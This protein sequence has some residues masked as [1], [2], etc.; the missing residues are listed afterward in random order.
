MPPEKEKQNGDDEITR[1]WSAIGKVSRLANRHQGMWVVVGVILVV[2]LASLFTLTK[3]NNDA[4]QIAIK[5]IGESS[6][7]TAENTD[8]MK[9][10][11]T[12]YMAANQERINEITRRIERCEE[13]LK[14]VRR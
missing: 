3:M 13:E 14:D 4:N 7:K 2:A 12:A 9:L 5:A 6:E 1:I 8:Q 10:T 11:V